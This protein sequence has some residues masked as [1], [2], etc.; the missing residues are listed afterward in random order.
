[1]TLVSPSLRAELDAL[2]GRLRGRV[3][4]RMQGER[5]SKVRGAAGEFF[6]HRPYSAGDDVRRLDWK[7]YARSGQ[8]VL[9]QFRVE[10]ER[11]LRFVIDSSA[12]MESVY[13]ATQVLTA[14]LA[15]VA[16]A[17]GERVQLFAG[18]NSAD[19][20]DVPRRALKGFP[21]LAMGLEATTCQGA[22]SLHDLINDVVRHAPRPGV[23]GLLSDFLDAEGAE[24]AIKNARSRGH[25]VWL[26]HCRDAS[27][28]VQSLWGDYTLEDAETGE[29]CEVTIDDGT[30]AEYTDMLN[31][32][33]QSLEQLAR[34]VGGHYLPFAPQE[35]A[36][37]ICARIYG[38]GAASSAVPAAA[39]SGA[40]SGRAAP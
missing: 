12:S 22:T 27:D 10:E 3:T 5:R 21:G 17:E 24:R 4:S 33:A 26:L 39:A 34:T 25:E 14:A 9:K 11:A 30:L 40:K 8:P 6:G 38:I 37:S 20:V 36:S 28:A 2:R 7:A 18:S 1:M 15:Y 35:R 13:H 31:R 16:L 23:L 29:L 19:W 32:H